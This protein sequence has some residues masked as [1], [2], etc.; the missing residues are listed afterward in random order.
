MDCLWNRKPGRKVQEVEAG[1]ALDRDTGE[2]VLSCLGQRALSGLLQPSPSFP[3]ASEPSSF[4]N[5]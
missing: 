5:A 4:G 3:A 2:G 1:V